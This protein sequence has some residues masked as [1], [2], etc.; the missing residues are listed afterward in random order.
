MARS[1]G[2]FALVDALPDAVVVLLAATT[3]LADTWFLF[4]LL[5][6]GYW[7]GTDRY[8]SDPRRAGAVAIA[9]VTL[10][11]AAVTL[12]KVAF[13]VPRPPAEPVPPTWLVGPLE[14]WFLAEVASDG[15][16]FPS[17]HAAG[18]A[19]A[20]G[21]LALLAD[22]SGSSRGRLVAAAG[23][24]VAVAASRVVL[25]VHYL[26]DIVVGALL[27]VGL[28]LVGLRLAG[29]GR[30]RAD[31]GRPLDPTPVFLLAAVV[32]GAAV[33]VAMAGGHGEEVVEAGIGV[34]TG[35]GG[36]AGWRL[37]TG[38][39]PAVPLRLAVPTLA[40][41]GAVWVVVFATL[42]SLPVTV[43]LTIATVAVVL[44]MPAIAASRVKKA[45]S[46]A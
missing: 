16:G 33:V 28:L 32:S 19:A 8:A 12:G 30:F 23:V 35:L 10:V 40:V 45:D 7:F 27:A 17:G 39:E 41:T 20:Y 4:A 38:D 43:G 36:A 2:E 3:H 34:G 37:M 1:V 24:A 42:P 44:A 31:H 15:F 25:Q 5:A 9:L 13:A 6:T 26:V 29:D 18:A 11:L 21:A 46:A 22:R 14:G